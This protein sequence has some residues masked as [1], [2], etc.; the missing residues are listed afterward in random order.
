MG[1][2]STEP[3]SASLPDFMMTM[4]LLF[5]YRL[6]KQDSLTAKITGKAGGREQV[7]ANKA[8]DSW[9]STRGTA[10][11]DKFQKSRNNVAFQVAQVAYIAMGH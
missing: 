9:C 2:I 10:T 6:V 11:D 3:G 4:L 8:V 5:Y 7:R 1:R